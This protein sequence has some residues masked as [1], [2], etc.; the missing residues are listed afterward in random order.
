MNKN[1]NGPVDL[2]PVPS[3]LSAWFLLIPLR[4]QEPCRKQAGIGHWGRSTIKY[5]QPTMRHTLVLITL[6]FSVLAFSAN[7][8]DATALPGMQRIKVRLLNW[9]QDVTHLEWSPPTDIST[10]PRCPTDGTPPPVNLSEAC[11][12]ALAVTRKEHDTKK[13]WCVFGQLIP[14]S[15]GQS[16]MYG[17]KPEVY[18]YLIVLD[19]RNE[20]SAP[21]DR[22]ITF[23]LVFMD[24]SV[25]SARTI[26]KPI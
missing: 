12:I 11:E 21:S 23:K 17:T 3:G 24:K 20:T 9:T 10:F 13:I 19:V 22:F 8:D 1:A 6:A 2:I 7:G 14:L 16:A 25:V 26:R 4:G 5:H 15:D 18:A